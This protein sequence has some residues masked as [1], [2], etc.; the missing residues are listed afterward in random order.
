MAMELEI[1]CGILKAT[2]LTEGAPRREAEKK[3]DEAVTNSPDQLAMALQ[4]VLAA[5]QSADVPVEL[6]QE[7]GVILRQLVAGLG[8]HKPVWPNLRPEVRKTVQA[9]LLASLEQDPNAPCKRSTGKVISA[10]GNCCD[11]FDEVGKEWPEVLPALSRMVA[12]SGEV[13]TQ[14]NA[15][16]ILKDLVP[17]IG[18][19]MLAHSD[20]ALQL[21]KVAMESQAPPVR[22]AGVQ[23][24]LQLIETCEEDEVACLGVVCAPLIVVLQAFANDL[25]EEQLKE[26]L[27]ALVAAADE[28][29]EFF[30]VHDA[31]ENL[32]STLAKIVS[33]PAETFGDAEVPHTAMEACMSL[34]VGL[35]DEISQPEGL[36]MLEHIVGLNLNWMLEVEQDVS[37]WTEAGKQT[38]DDEC[39]DERVGIAEENLDRLAE[40]IEEE[41]FMP[42]L[43][44]VLRG[45]LQSATAD[46]RT[47]RSCIMAISQ[48]VEHLED[49]ALVDQCIDFIIPYLAH[50]HP[51]VRYAAFW[52]I[53]Q[54]CY[55]HSPHVQDKHHKALLVAIVAGMK[56]EN[57]RVATA[58][59]TTLSAVVDEEL[60]QENLEPHIQ[61]LL[62][63]VIKLLGVGGSRCMQEQCLSGIAAIAKA[64]EEL[65]VP[66]YVDVMPLLTRVVQNA[67]S[68]DE[69]TLR[70]KA[71]EC[72]GAI[73]QEVGKEVF[74]ADAPAVMEVMTKLSQAGFA[75]DD[76][77]RESV[78][79]AAGAIAE[80]LEKD[81]KPYIAP[82]LPSIFT[83]LQQRPTEIAP[84]DMPDDDDDEN[85]DMSLQVV[86]DKVLGLKT[87]V[88]TEMS[89][90]V[91]LLNTFID[92]VG[93]EFCEFM[94]ATC[95]NLAPF[96]DF[97]LSEELRSKAFATWVQLAKCAKEGVVSGK[98]D[99][100]VLRELVTEFLKKIATSM[101][102][103]PVDEDGQLEPSALHSL[104]AQA[105]AVANVVQKAGE[106][107]LTKD[108]VQDLL[109]V[110]VALIGRLKCSPDASPELGKTRR[111]GAP[112]P[113]LD[114]DGDEKEE[115]DG[116]GKEIDDSPT[117]QTARLALV[118]A[119]GA[120]MSANRDDF[121][122]VALSTFMELVRAFVQKDRSD[123]DRGLGFYMADEVV[124]CL[125]ERSLPFWNGFMNEALQGVSD[126]SA[127]IRQYA[128]ATIGH[129]AI[130]PGFAP[131]AQAA[132]SAV[133]AKLQ[134]QG[135]RHRRR[136][137][138]DAQAKQGALAVDACVRAIGQ[139]CEH[140]EQ[141]LGAHA[142][143][144]WQMW[145]SLLP[146]KYDLEAGHKAHTQLLRLVVQNHAYFTAPEL[147]PKV[148]TVFAEIY[149]TKFSTPELDKNIAHAVAQVG[150]VNLKTV[151][152]N[153]SEK[154]MKKVDQML[155]KGGA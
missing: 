54:V 61:V 28:E 55:D 13:S 91:D 146:M 51:R 35:S 82:L 148:L 124:E 43:F 26:C 31:V 118:D 2:Q 131:M 88:L 19:G 136:R 98:I 44:K 102:T 95:Q 71:F 40:H 123:A 141:Q 149:R 5:W 90:A 24:I 72:I 23:L 140:Q 101:A 59:V 138:A 110:I 11:D 106:G 27:L 119:V 109:R 128:T 85:E 81:F 150:E 79:E 84:E 152:S 15:L 38:D 78:H 125:G 86:G 76:P 46:W 144:G 113:D 139:I 33:S 145:L 75:A 83:V 57:I 87:S 92:A 6:R 41:I 37:A 121:T 42:A 47:V 153:F 32:Y 97:A 137:A 25:H 49:E 114:E 45:A 155:K 122:E 67:T 115:L 133:Y 116:D 66:F 21:L 105:T 4:A 16:D 20:Q 80:T 3:L 111:K 36:P 103:C 39:D 126:K 50:A 34:A 143:M 29:A 132:A 107:V 14:V 100:S 104:Q 70:G 58:A 120:V 135:D 53:G 30:K 9:T 134:K 69:R 12:S 22:S 1:M 147:L 73:G 18:A 56:D 60:D 63:G 48:S 89:E 68:E 96:L 112:A 108:V 129:A 17:T 99:V 93:D 52:A 62:E 74:L 151:C 8:H 127:I 117:M 10:I 154:Q 7:A 65:F 142:A 130:Q 64:G 94:P 77:Q